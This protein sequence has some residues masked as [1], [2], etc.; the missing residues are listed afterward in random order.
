VQ[1]EHVLGAVSFISDL[2]VYGVPVQGCDGKAGM[3]AIKLKDGAS[4]DS[5][6]WQEFHNECLTNLPV[7]A[8]PLFIR[9]QFGEMKMTATFKHQKNVLVKDGFDP[10]CMGDDVLLFY[11]SRDG[12]VTHLDGQMYADINNG[13]IRV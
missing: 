6:N 4:L 7:Y 10:A 9:I 13:V 3:V 11:S 2:S 1:V 5:L 8:R 12:K